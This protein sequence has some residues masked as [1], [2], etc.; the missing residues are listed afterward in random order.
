MGLSV[1]IICKVRQKLK[2]T[3]KYAKYVK[4]CKVCLKLVTEVWENEI[5]GSSS[6]RG[7]FLA[8]DSELV[9]DSWN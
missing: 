1:C 7:Q 2:S 6:G 4:A 8:G 9:A 3:S 5:S